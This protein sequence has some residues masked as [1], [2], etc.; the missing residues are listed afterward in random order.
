M[1]GW[2]KTKIQF[3]THDDPNGSTPKG[4]RTHLLLESWGY[5]GYN[6]NTK[7]GSQL[8]ALPIF[9]ARDNKKRTYRQRIYI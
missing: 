4:D 8:F 2:K 6:L 7:L 1:P 9:L 3:R 5:E